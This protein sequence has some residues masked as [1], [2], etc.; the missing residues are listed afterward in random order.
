MAARRVFVSRKSA[1]SMLAVR[2]RRARQEGTGPSDLNAMPALTRHLFAREKE[3]G[4]NCLATISPTVMIPRWKRLAST[5]FR[6]QFPIMCTTLCPTG[7]AAGGIPDH[8]L[9]GAV[10]EIHHVTRRGGVVADL[11]RLVARLARAN[12]VEEVRQ[13]KDGGVRLGV[14]GDVFRRGL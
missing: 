7:A 10:G 3:K 5:T 11:R 2:G 13:V 6:S 8:F 14:K 1:S 9:A 12:G 4:R